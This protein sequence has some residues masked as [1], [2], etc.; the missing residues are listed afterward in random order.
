MFGRVVIPKGIADQVIYFQAILHLLSN[1]K[2]LN[3]NK[4]WDI[5]KGFKVLKIIVP[6]TLVSSYARG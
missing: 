4:K 1:L 5:S 2:D 6:R 3:S